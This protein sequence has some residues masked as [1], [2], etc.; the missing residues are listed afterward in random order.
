MTP[1][2]ISSRSPPPRTPPERRSGRES[3]VRSSAPARTLCLAADVENGHR[4]AGLPEGLRF[5]DLRHSYAT[6]LVSDGLPPN[7]VQRIMGHED[8]T[9]TLGIYTDVPADFVQ[10][11][12]DMLV[13]D[14]LWIEA[15]DGP[16]KTKTPPRRG[17][18]LR[19]VL[20]GV[21]GFE[22]AASSSRI[23][24]ARTL[25]DLHEYKIC[26]SAASVGGRSAPYGAVGRH[27]IL[28]ILPPAARTSITIGSTASVT[29]SPPRRCGAIAG[30]R[31]SR[32]TRHHG[33]VRRGLRLARPVDDVQVGQLVEADGA[34]MRRRTAV[35]D[36]HVCSKS[37]M[38]MIAV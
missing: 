15:E 4:R 8:V 7:V 12:E 25:A 18:E 33:V 11:V 30:P 20:V 34:A 19:K 22:P 23:I 36:P 31:I 35:R 1:A 24:M 16:R 28:P 29:P 17:R 38:I 9:T 26:R 21:T 2:A 3:G 32:P 6:W 14:P 37:S 13:V 5:H 10:R 27:S